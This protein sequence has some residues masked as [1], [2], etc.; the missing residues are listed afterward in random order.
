MVPNLKVPANFYRP[1]FKPISDDDR[2]LLSSF[3]QVDQSTHKSVHKNTAIEI[4]PTDHM[5]A[6]QSDKDM[7]ETQTTPE[8]QETPAERVQLQLPTLEPMSAS[9][10][11][12]SRESDSNRDDKHEKN[13][14]E[15]NLKIV[16]EGAY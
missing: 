5:T 7:L 16:H 8:T 3:L 11:S 12:A 14:N 15:N 10:G 6:P 2:E 13:S 9:D 1:T 4:N